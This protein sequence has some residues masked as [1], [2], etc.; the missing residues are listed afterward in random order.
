MGKR[1]L[2]CRSARKVNLSMP[3]RDR[4]RLLAS[5]NAMRKLLTL[6]ALL[7]FSGFAV[8]CSCSQMTGSA[9]YA[10]AAIVVRGRVVATTLHR[11][12]GLGDELGESIVRA[13]VI[14]L[15]IFKGQKTESIEVVGGSDYRNPVCTLPLVAGGE[16]IFVLGKDLVVSHCNLWL[17]DTPDRQEAIKTFRRMKAQ[18]K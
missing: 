12:P 10:N 18:A 17:S 9:M 1:G 13:K 11:N 5:V 6:I 4:G 7:A 3:L 8:A 14:S 15:E 2:T 16:Y